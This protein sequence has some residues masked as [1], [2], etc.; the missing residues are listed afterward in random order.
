METIT[1]DD[2]E[3]DLEQLTENAR[4]QLGS[5]QAVDQKLAQLQVEMAILQTARAAYSSALKVELGKV[6]ES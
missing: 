5:I 6:T 4:A 2:V 3:Y 1:I